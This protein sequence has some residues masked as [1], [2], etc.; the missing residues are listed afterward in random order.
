MDTATLK[1]TIQNGQAV[2]AA[3]ETGAALDKMA[4][5]G[6]AANA[7]LIGSSTGLTKAQQ[8]LASQS[9]ATQA[10]VARLGSAA[11][12]NAAATRKAEEATARYIMTLQKAETAAYREN[13]ARTAASLESVATA[14]TKT[15]PG[16]SRLAY[17]FGALDARLAGVST[18]T[19]R[20]GSILSNLFLGGP[21]TVGIGLGIAAIIGGWK[22]LGEQ[23]DELGDKVSDAMKKMH[24]T[25]IT[26]Q[27]AVGDLQLAKATQDIADAQAALAKAQRGVSHPDASLGGASVR[28]VS[29][30][31][32]TNAEKALAAA[33]AE[34]FDA[35]Q[36]KSQ[37]NYQQRGDAERDYAGNLALLVKSNNATH[38]ERQRALALYK[39]DVA[40]IA[41]LGKTQTDNVR[42]AA[43]IGDTQSLGDAL[44]HKERKGRE[45]KPAYLDAITTGSVAVQ[46]SVETSITWY[47]KEV[48]EA[49]RA[50]AARAKFIGGAS[51]KSVPTELLANGS[52]AMKAFDAAVSAARDTQDRITLRNAINAAEGKGPVDEGKGTVM[53]NLRK[54]A[55]QS[56]AVVIDQL[57]RMGASGKVLQ[58]VLENI[59]KQLKDIG[60]NAP[61]SDQTSLTDK[62]TS[63]LRTGADA[64]NL[65]GGPKGGKIANILNTAANAA[66]NVKSAAAE[67]FHNPI[68]D[69]QAVLS[70]ASLGKQILGLGSQSHDAARA[71]Q[72]ASESIK[73]MIATLSASVN[74]DALGGQLAAAQA[75]DDAR[76]S[77]IN[78]ALSGKKRETERNQQLAADDALFA[79]QKQQITQQYAIQQT[80][81]KESLAARLDRAKGLS[82]QADLEDLA[83]K[84][85]EEMN[86]AIL[87]GRDAAYMASL[88][89]V[90]LA[91]KTQLAN[92]AITQLA[93]APTGFFAERYFGQFSTPASFP[94]I[95]P[96]T[97]TS[98][99]S[100]GA[101]VTGNTI[102][103]TVPAS[104]DPEATAKA[105]VKAIRNIGNGIGGMGTT[106]AE[107][108]ELMP[109]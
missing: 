12:T 7:R 78:S 36:Y 72:E 42:R 64:A 46:Q 97:T 74:H 4:T 105:V 6:E 21:W 61:K 51:L 43:L 37:L 107:T 20:F 24:A 55:V 95:T 3:Q 27:V 94:G 41:R 30:V 28:T 102:N 75:A 62:I 10:A 73:S 16:L 109:S 82:Y 66:D 63:G 31:A 29:P 22:L 38:A 32:V 48:E 2:Q 34:L 103:I 56:G 23:A 19:G 70:V 88:A 84:Q 15:L 33:N 77:Q 26:A 91:E 67:G 5:Q 53:D 60:A 40:E 68:A 50:I 106:V 8:F 25:S 80:F 47:K 99:T 71:I 18:I 49:D 14:T 45:K 100:T 83:V 35:Q 9:A 81:D 104:N 58:I 59:N 52:P 89:Q 76:K 11:V 17:S 98:S 85:Q 92:Q 87:A 54:S 86:A 101:T 1:L 96:P 108:M 93:N 57:Q 13:V 65:F 79:K 39:S 69:A 90:Q 44:F